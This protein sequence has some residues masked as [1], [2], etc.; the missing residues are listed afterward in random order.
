[1]SLTPPGSWLLRTVDEVPTDVM[2]QGRLAW[3]EHRAK[4]RAVAERHD[5]QH[6]GT[7]LFRGLDES[8]LLVINDPAPDNG[9]ERVAQPEN[10]ARDALRA[11]GAAIEGLGAEAWRN[12]AIVHSGRLDVEEKRMMDHVFGRLRALVQED[13]RSFDDIRG[14]VESEGADEWFWPL[15]LSEA[16]ADP[17]VEGQDE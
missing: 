1:M 10:E 15:V 13:N 9:E 14:L 2:V 8:V 3:D 12:E 6:V 4:I 16:L 11:A 5:G 7:V 17:R